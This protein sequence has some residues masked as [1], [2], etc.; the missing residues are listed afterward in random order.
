MNKRTMCFA[1]VA[2]AGLLMV[3]CSKSSSPTGP[4][5]PSTTWTYTVDG[6][7]LIVSHPETIE[8]FCQGV[9]LLSDTTPAYSDTSTYFFSAGQDTMFVVDLSSGDTIVL[10]RSGA[11]SG[12]QGTWTMHDMG[13]DM[14]ITVGASTITSSVCFSDM[15]MLI[16]AIYLSSYDVSIN[17]SSCSSV[18]ITG[19]TT[20]E[21]VT[22][23]GTQTGDS[24]DNTD[25]DMT[26]SSSD[27]THASA[28]TY[29]NPTTCPNSGPAWW[30]AFL[31]A[32]Q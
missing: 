16:Y 32:N 12:I 21:V 15:F 19:N 17:S 31:T 30:P 5:S 1:A 25:F 27:P 6:S 2:A 29:A 7:T 13:I 28:T 14:T 10:V 18:T 3:T 22:I 20:G 26:F 24:P 8:T 11:G 9:T 23:T 4:G